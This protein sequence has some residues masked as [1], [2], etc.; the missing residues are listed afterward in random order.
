[1]EPQNSCDQGEVAQIR[2]LRNEAVRSCLV[3]DFV[4]CLKGR[5]G[6][7]EREVTKGRSSRGDPAKG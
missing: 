2:R 5:Q 6:N 1:M 4:S 7:L 3:G